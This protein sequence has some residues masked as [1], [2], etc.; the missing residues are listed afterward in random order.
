MCGRYANSRTLKCMAANW[1]AAIT[2]GAESWLP[3]D[4]IRPTNQIP[5]LLSNPNRIGLMSWGWKRDFAKS[6]ILINARSEEAA[7]KPTFAKAMRQ[8]RCLVPADSW[9]EWQAHKTKFR[10]IPEGLE[11]WGIAALWEG[12]TV[13]LLTTASH[14]SIAQALLI[15]MIGC[16]VS[17]G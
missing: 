7:A 3:N 13:V 16:H 5:V 4:D 2:A 17:L 14:P 8:H 10:L 11:T 6:G 9:Y 1:S 15:Y 12:S